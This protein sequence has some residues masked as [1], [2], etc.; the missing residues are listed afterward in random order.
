MTWRRPLAD[1][2]KIPYRLET[3]GWGK[4]RRTRR[5]CFSMREIQAALTTSRRPSSG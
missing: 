2:E 5:M 1:P 3:R 4:L